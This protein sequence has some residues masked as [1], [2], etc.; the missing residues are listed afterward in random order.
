MKFYVMKEMS[1][2]AVNGEVKVTYDPRRALMVCDDIV[3]AN[4]YF[5]FCV[6]KR[7]GRYALFADSTTSPCR[8]SRLQLLMT[9]VIDIGN[10]GFEEVR[11]CS[12]Y[13]NQ[14]SGRYEIVEH[15][16]RWLVSENN[17]DE[18]VV[19]MNLFDYYKS[20]SLPCSLG[21]RIEGMII[22]HHDYRHGYEK[23]IYKIRHG[24]KGVMLP[25]EQCFKVDPV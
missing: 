10:S 6:S 22:D 5:E 2:V 18:K 9:G 13:K 11:S 24:I 12:L 1:R 20:L 16:A 21:Y 23:K 7:P 25:F 15:A 19:K 4:K 3:A 17:R 14:Q 8:L